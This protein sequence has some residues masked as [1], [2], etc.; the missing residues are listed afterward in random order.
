[1][2]KGLG[3][4]SIDNY[5]QASPWILVVLKRGPFSGQ[6]T[7]SGWPGS[8]GRIPATAPGVCTA[9]PPKSMEPPSHSPRRACIHIAIHLCICRSISIGL[10]LYLHISI[11]IAISISISICIRMCIWVYEYIVGCTRLRLR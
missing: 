6:V 7:I 9:R 3:P 5:F 10:Y 11:S 8:S 4:M 1:M 2:Y